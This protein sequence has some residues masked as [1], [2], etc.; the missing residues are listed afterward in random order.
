MYQRDGSMQ[1]QANPLTRQAIMVSRH[2]DEL[3]LCLYIP[4]QPLPCT[5]VHPSQR[6]KTSGTSRGATTA[7]RAFQSNRILQVWSSDWSWNHS[8]NN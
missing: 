1:G 6:F 3:L 7:S 4:K 5:P 8:W 2:D